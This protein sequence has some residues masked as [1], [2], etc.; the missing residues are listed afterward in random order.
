MYLAPTWDN[1][2]TWIATLRHIAK[3]GRVHV[4]GVTPCQRGTD[5][6][7][8]FGGLDALYGGDDDW[9][10]RGN[11]AIVGPDGRLLAGP[12]VGEPGILY[13]DLDLAAARRDRRMFDPTGHYARPDIF[14]LTVDARI[15]RPVTFVEDEPDPPTT[16]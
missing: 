5:V 9:L 10:S 13:A 4:V 1:S 8:A 7:D 12:L 15:K 2:D 3:E 6:R 16:R 11:T 14:R